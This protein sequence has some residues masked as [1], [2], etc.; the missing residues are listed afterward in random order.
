MQGLDLLLLC[1]FGGLFVRPFIDG[2][3]LVLFAAFLSLATLLAA[4]CLDAFYALCVL[5]MKAP[6]VNG[7]IDVMLKIE[8]SFVA[9]PTADW[10]I[11][12]VSERKL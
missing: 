9:N 8:T 4:L 12:T 10:A 3:V 5:G 11:E 7:A 1:L 6:G 2:G